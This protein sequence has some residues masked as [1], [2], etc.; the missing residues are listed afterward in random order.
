MASQ[1]VLAAF[2]STADAFSKIDEARLLRKSL[3]EESLEVQLKPILE[4]LRRKIDF[5]QRYAPLVHDSHATQ[6]QQQLQAAVAGLNEQANRGNA[7]EYIANKQGLLSS[8]NT[9]LD[10]ANAYWPPF[11]AA[12]VESR[13]FLEDEGIRKE[14]ERTLN[15][16]QTE[17]R[18]ALENVRRESTAAIDE[19]RK[20]AEQIEARARKTAT[21][22]SVD[23]AQKQFRAAEKQLL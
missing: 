4:Q 20:L 1:S 23:E 21:K 5:A 8:L 13:G 16:M 9:W 6:V 3:G 14:Y 12:A 22:I 11:V 2:K 7:S 17:T 19:A 18:A 15:Q 10:G